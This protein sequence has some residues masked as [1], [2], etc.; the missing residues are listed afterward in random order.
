MEN[1]TISQYWLKIIKQYQLDILI[2]QHISGLTWGNCL[3]ARRPGHGKKFG[4]TDVYRRVLKGDKFVFYVLKSGVISYKATVSEN[5]VWGLEVE[6]IPF[7][8]AH[9]GKPDEEWEWVHRFSFTDILPIINP[10]NLRTDKDRIPFLK[11]FEK[12]GT[13]FMNC[14]MWKLRQEDYD[15]IVLP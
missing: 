8:T 13:A 3:K 4:L 2:N 6:R 12:Y 7:M 11:N 1:K 9:K 14:S 5:P 10:I 15:A